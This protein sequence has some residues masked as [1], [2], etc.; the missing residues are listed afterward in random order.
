MPSRRPKKRKKSRKRNEWARR[1]SDALKS[2]ARLTALAGD[3]LPVDLGHLRRQ[4]AV[5][6]IEFWPLLADGGLV[7]HEDGFKILVRCGRRQQKH[8]LERLFDEDE[9]GQRLPPE[10]VRQARF[11]IAHEIAHTFFYDIRQR[12]PVA[13][14]FVTKQ[15]E[16]ADIEHVCSTLAGTLLLPEQALRRDFRNADL[17]Q[18][19]I[20]KKISDT[21]LISRPALV[22]RIRALKQIEHPFGVV[23]AVHRAKEKWVISAISAHY[24]LPRNLESAFCGKSITS[25]TGT[26]A[27]MLIEGVIDPFEFSW[28][29]PND[30]SRW[31]FVCATEKKKPRQQSLFMTLRRIVG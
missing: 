24:S 30:N 22:W 14:E 7:T 31:T 10:I 2:A 26:R 11:T 29:N 28:I 1:K 18:P 17:L 4:R 25:L 19:E 21:A 23:V 8:E 5:T 15:A 12:P 9:T 20:L 27:P 6:S 13:R 16:P 3:R